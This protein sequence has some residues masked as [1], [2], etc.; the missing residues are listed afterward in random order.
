MEHQSAIAY[1][2]KYRNGYLGMDRSGTGWGSKWDYIIIHES[3]HEWFGNNITAKDIADMWIQ[4]GFTTYSETIFTECQYGKQAGNT[5]TRGLRNDITHD[6]P[7]IGPYGVNQEGSS[8]MYDKGSN[9]IHTIR[10]VINND[11]LFKKILRGL[12]ADFY[13]Q[14]INSAMLE[15]YFSVKSRKDLSKI[16]DQYLRAKNIPV[17]EY[18]TAKGLISFRWADCIRGFNMPVKIYLDKEGKQS[19]WIRPTGAW[20][21]VRPGAGHNPAD[22]SPDSNFYIRTRK[23]Q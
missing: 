15:K 13:H 8:D 17:L 2:N 22:F 11:S 10:Q 7:V 19:R 18:K 12:N 14:T 20:Q 6:K 1:G 16:F 9:L 21:T 4:E 5:Y 3:G 23:V